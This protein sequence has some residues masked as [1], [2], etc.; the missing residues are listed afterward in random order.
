MD[1]E[2]NCKRITR[3]QCSSRKPWESKGIRYRL[4][5]IRILDYKTNHQ[6]LE[7]CKSTI[8]SLSELYVFHPIDPVKDNIITTFQKHITF[9]TDKDFDWPYRMLSVQQHKSCIPLA[10]LLYLIFMRFNASTF[11]EPAGHKKSNVF[12]FSLIESTILQ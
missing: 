3:G 6:Q 5:S 7:K 1:S 9:V 11:L 4:S 8:S 12:T 2:K 10:Y